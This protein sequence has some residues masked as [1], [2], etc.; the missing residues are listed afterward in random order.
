M[1]RVYLLL[2]GNIGDVAA[3]FEKSI[4]MI[5]ELGKI[6]RLS[7]LY[8][9]EAWGFKSEDR[10]LNQAIALDTE[11]DPIALLD[12]TQAIES[13]LGRKR[14]TVGRKYENREIDIDILLYGD[15]TLRTKR[16]TIPHALL[17]ERAFALKPLK[18]IAAE[19]VHPII[20]KTVEELYSDL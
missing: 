9:S 13:A 7:S 18:E 8:E 15:M 2:G 10:F 3:K 5:A 20:G 1:A 16:L 19:V 11:L 14:K 4:K 6:V 17:H 12:A